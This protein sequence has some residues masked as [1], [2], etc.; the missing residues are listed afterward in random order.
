MESSHWY[1]SQSQGFFKRRGVGES[2]HM[3]G[4]HFVS[5]ILQHVNISQEIHILDLPMTQ[6]DKQVQSGIPFSGCCLLQKE[7]C[8]NRIVPTTYL[9][10]IVGHKATK[11]AALRC[12]LVC[13]SRDRQNA[14]GPKEADLSKDQEAVLNQFGS[15]PIL[16]LL[17]CTPFRD[18]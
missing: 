4:I 16:L 2:L 14:G 3:E 7:I 13:Q 9:F 11:A 10:D 18:V 1:G 6:D 8:T 12:P 17:T 15:A 5:G